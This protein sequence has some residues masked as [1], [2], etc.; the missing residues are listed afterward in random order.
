[1]LENWQHFP[2]TGALFRCACA[3]QG[4]SVDKGGTLHVLV[5]EGDPGSSFLLG[6]Q[7][8]HLGYDQVSVSRS[9]AYAH[10]RIYA[11]DGGRP[12]LVILDVVNDMIATTTPLATAIRARG[13]AFIA[14]VERAAAPL[15]AAYD[16]AIVLPRP[17]G[18]SDVVDAICL[19]QGYDPWG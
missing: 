14:V 11:A 18:I 10:E 9:L 6:L 5:V 2:F 7:L 19:A 4:K 8:R 17:P 13:I 1:M 16:A 12:H 15:P 3:E